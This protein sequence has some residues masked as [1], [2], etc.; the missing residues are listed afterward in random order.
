MQPSDQ[1]LS[2]KP[3]TPGARSLLVLAALSALLVF[4]TFACLL[5]VGVLLCE[6]TVFVIALRLGFA[7]FIARLVVRHF[8]LQGT[9]VRAFWLQKGS[10]LRVSVGPAEAPELFRRLEG[11]GAR[12]GIPVPREVLVEMG[13]NAWVRMGGFRQGTGK[14]TLGLGLDLLA[15]LSGDEVESVLAHE[16][17]HAK[18][19]RRG[20]SRW[21]HSGLARS[22]RLTQ[23]LSARVDSSNSTLTQVDLDAW[24]VE[25]ADPL[26]RWIARLVGTY[27]RQ[28]EFDADR[29]AA[30]LCG[31]GTF[32]SALVKLQSLGE[33]AG[34]LTLV[35][36]IAQLQHEEGFSRWLTRELATVAM[37]NPAEAEAQ[38]EVLDRYSTHPRLADRLAA[39]PVQPAGLAS[40]TSTEPALHWLRDPEVVARRL[41]DSIEQVIAR[42]E[43]KDSFELKRVLRQVR[44]H[45]RLRPLQWVA[46]LPLFVGLLALLLSVVG[47]FRSEFLV[48]PLLVAVVGIGLGVF[49]YRR[50]RYRDFAEVPVPSF[51]SLKLSLEKPAP[52][53]D[54]AGLQSRLEEDLRQRLKSAKRSQRRRH[55]I[56]TGYAA[57][58]EGRYLEAHVVGRLGLELSKS[59]PEYQL[60]FGIAAAAFGQ[61][62]AARE[63][64]QALAVNTGFSSFGTAWGGAWIS[65]CLGDL[66]FAEVLLDQ[67]LAYRPGQSTELGL[68]AVARSRR[69]KKR[70]ALRCVREA[71]T[72]APNDQELSKLLIQLLIDTG[73]VSEAADQLARFESVAADEDLMVSWVRVRLLQQR[74]TEADLWAAQ[75]AER[76]IAAPVWLR[77]GG[78]YE[79]AR[80]W[81]TA[82]DCFHRALG[83]GQYPEAYLGLARLAGRR[84]EVAQARSLIR[85][86]VN[87]A[88][89]PGPGSA[90]VP[91]VLPMAFGQWRELEE[92]VLG[93]QAWR[94]R[95]G[96]SVRPPFLAERT[97]L[98]YAGNHEEARAILGSWLEATEPG[99]SL[100]R[101]AVQV[102]RAPRRQQPAGPERPGI[103]GIF[104]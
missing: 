17:T 103:V 36:R 23:A 6:V 42:E 11:L 60:V 66:G 47:M 1:L 101:G 14:T 10:E 54:L 22:A 67:A 15:G 55:L 68:L 7:G 35:E 74:F 46:I 83:L 71:I 63:A 62:S 56:E 19:V 37:P 12:L 91:A 13:A 18:L 5:V 82:G 98:I 99:N 88:V 45:A 90:G 49:L 72:L 44:R 40:K 34:R 100:A 65:V 77:L 57:L 89:S 21:L 27:S 86:A 8:S 48:G 97:L 52:E 38:S 41:V 69:G 70:S 80:R 64:L 76:S 75:L 26:T 3:L 96:T 84:R 20:F 39:L 79:V 51:G 33:L 28:D 53:G 61:H 85:S 102:F 30:E 25:V 50:S 92:P 81:E 9:I 43:D 24:I 78:A 95:L 4:Y 16:M 58:A 93:C 31:S 32:R 2:E 59:L 29:G 87:T 94:A 104:S 73:Q